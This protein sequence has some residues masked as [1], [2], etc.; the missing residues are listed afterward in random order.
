ME[1]DSILLYFKKKDLAVVEIH[2]ET[3]YVLGDGIRCPLMLYPNML[4][5]V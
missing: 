4:V 1:P 2:V 5:I 3:N